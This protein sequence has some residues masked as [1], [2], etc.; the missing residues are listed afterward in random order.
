MARKTDANSD[1]Q[2]RAILDQLNSFTVGPPQAS[3]GL[4][5]DQ[6]PASVI[7]PADFDQVTNQI[8]ISQ[9]NVEALNL[10]GMV[11]PLAGMRSV[12]G[13]ISQ[14]LQIVS[15][16]GDTSG[17]TFTV[18]QPDK[19]DEIW[20]LNALDFSITGGSGNTTVIV[21]LADS[22]TTLKLLEVTTA[23][24]SLVLSDDIDAPI[25]ISRDVRLIGIWAR[26]S[27]TS[28]TFKGSVVRVR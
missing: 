21:Y 23:S 27:G 17:S 1:P 26:T 7:K 10:L 18:F 12:S 16:S 24:T 8:H 5:G 19:S 22:S 4:V 15:A 28:G 14:S 6:E 11:G 9:P 3:T 13:P 2:T 20:V 25:Y